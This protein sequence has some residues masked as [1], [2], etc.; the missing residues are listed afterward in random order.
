MN[1]TDQ[2]APDDTSWQAWLATAECQR[3]LDN[4]PAQPDYDPEPGPSTRECRADQLYH[5]AIQWAAANEP[6]ASKRRIL[7]R[8]AYTSPEMGA[9]HARAH[10]YAQAVE[11]HQAELQAVI[12]QRDQLGAHI[13]SISHVN[14]R[15]RVQ[16][17]Q[18]RIE[19]Q[20]A[21]ERL[22]AALY[23]AVLVALVCGGLLILGGAQR[24]LRGW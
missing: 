7:I 14:R 1:W 2:P 8:E 4:L 17:Q 24:W 13:A 15:A 16:L 10:G 23:R 9:W 22:L 18:E 21:R 19:A 3:L 12:D 20:A 11:E 5:E 6:D